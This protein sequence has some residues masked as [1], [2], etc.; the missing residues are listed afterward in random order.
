MFLHNCWVGSISP[1][2]YCVGDT[3]G[4][5]YIGGRPVLDTIWTWHHRT[6]ETTILGIMHI[7]RSIQWLI[8]RIGR[9]QSVYSVW[10]VR[11]LL[12]LSAHLMCLRK[13][14]KYYKQVIHLFYLS[15][16][17]IRFRS[18]LSFNQRCFN[19]LIFCPMDT[20]SLFTIYPWS[21]EAVQPG[22]LQ[23]PMLSR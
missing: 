21:H 10:K 17:W 7:S 9:R 2:S 6:T 12:I 14:D 4:G 5:Q 19:K 13:N 15:F 3:C 11:N 18:F 1:G 8:S 23:E 16:N 20:S 22:F